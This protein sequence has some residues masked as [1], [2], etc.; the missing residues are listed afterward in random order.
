M[1]NRT[2][3]Y[4]NN[5]V[6]FKTIKKFEQNYG[7]RNFV[8]IALKEVDGGSKIITF[9]K[10]FIDNNGARRYKRSLGFEA[11]EEMKKF[12]LDSIKNI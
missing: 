12:L 3:E 11:S 5:K 10:G 1:E 6:E 9:S 2:G 4:E 7:N 8:E